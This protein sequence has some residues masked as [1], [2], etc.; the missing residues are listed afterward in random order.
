MSDDVLDE[1]EETFPLLDRQ[2]DLFAVE[3]ELLVDLSVPETDVSSPVY[4]NVRWTAGGG[5]D[6]GLTPRKAPKEPVIEDVEPEDLEEE[7]IEPEA[8]LSVSPDAE[9]KP[10]RASEERDHYADF[11]VE[12]KRLFKSKDMHWI[13]KTEELLWLL[14]DAPSEA[15]L[16][17]IVGDTFDEFNETIRVLRK[18]FYHFYD[19]LPR[20]IPTGGFTGRPKG[21]NDFDARIIDC[22]ELVKG[23]IVANQA[24]SEVVRIDQKFAQETV[25]P[26]IRKQGGYIDGGSVGEDVAQNIYGTRVRSYHAERPELI[27]EEAKEKL[28]ARKREEETA[29]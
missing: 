28:R 26:A 21:A 4:R 14:G 12:F 29:K 6:D 18:D 16:K 10:E 27:S 23:L 2:F 5:M 25:F 22:L 20:T 3:H 9:I 11:R 8:E 24:T 1:Y 19:P 7:C 17:S 15:R 13:D